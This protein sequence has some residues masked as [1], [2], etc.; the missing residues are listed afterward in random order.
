[1]IMQYF[2]MTILL[3]TRVSPELAARFKSAA[4]GT[5]KSAYQ[6]LRELAADYA[7]RNGRRRF[8]SEAYRERFGLPSPSRFKEA[9][10]DR[11]RQRH[12]KHH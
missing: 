2:R 6:V 7:S 1:M 9:L 10:R 12:E 8:A 5:G 4:R 3:Q 11:M